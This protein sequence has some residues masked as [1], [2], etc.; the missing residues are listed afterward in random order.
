VFPLG[1]FPAGVFNPGFWIQPPTIVDLNF[2]PSTSDPVD[3]GRPSVQFAN[4]PIPGTF[5]NPTLGPVNGLSG[6]DVQFQVAAS[7]SFDNPLP[8]PTS[9]ALVGIGLILGLLSRARL[10]R[11]QAG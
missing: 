7:T 10:L 3:K 11:K 9:M 5:Y 4:S 1:G 6:P 8:E 2:N